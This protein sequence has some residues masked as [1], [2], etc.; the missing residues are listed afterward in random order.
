MGGCVERSRLGDRRTPWGAGVSGNAV[1]AVAPAPVRVVQRL[2]GRR[3][4]KFVPVLGGNGT[5]IAPNGNI[6]VQKK[7]PW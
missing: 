7:K 1:G 3:C 6:F 2:G 5:K 4:R